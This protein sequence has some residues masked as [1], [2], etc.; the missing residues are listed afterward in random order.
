MSRE[1]LAEARERALGGRGPAVEE[2]GGGE[3]VERS[4]D[5][6]FD[7]VLEDVDESVADLARRSKVVTVVAIRE[8]ATTTSEDDVELAREPAGEAADAASESLTM[9]RFDDEMDVIALDGVVDDAKP[10]F[11]SAPQRIPERGID[12]LRSKAR[13]VPNDSHGDVNGIAT[14]KPRS[15]QV[16]QSRPPRPGFSSSPSALAT[17]RAKRQ[18]D[19]R[20]RA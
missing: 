8:D 4:R 17:T 13:R 9:R 20:R 6:V 14:R 18:L 7:S 12:A 2:A 11:G 5:A 15:L 16:S 10:V 19:L 1:G 3:E